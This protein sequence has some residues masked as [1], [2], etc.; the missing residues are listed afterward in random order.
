MTRRV[1]VSLHDVSPR[2]EKAVQHAL[3]L[4]REFEIPPVPLLVVPDFHGQW[5]L[6]AHP[7]F[8]EKL[9]SWQEQGHELVLHGYWHREL[10]LDAKAGGA[11]ESLKRQFLTGGE[12]EFL[13]LDA[14]RTTERLDAGLA[15][16][17]RC[18]LS[19]RPKGFIPPAWLHNDALDAELWKRG[20]TWTEN[21]AGLRY[22][23][24]AEVANP[25]ISWASRDRI[26]RIASRV[27]CPS[28]ERLW[29]KRPVM[30]I[31]LHPHDFDWPALERSIRLVLARA[32]KHGNWAL[33][34][35]VARS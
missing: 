15:M 16:W 20:F 1:L 18:G 11:G 5:P 3:D 29:R 27:V 12:G 4:L 33:P 25:V 34:G 2:H 35:A 28:L 17:D 23:S 31:A 14:A 8:L 32:R 9:R 24:G 10:E 30:R 13:S 26:R 21:H 22:Y 6:D 7:A 19:P